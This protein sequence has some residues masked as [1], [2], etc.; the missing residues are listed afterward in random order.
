MWINVDQS[1][2]AR[3]EPGIKLFSL[4]R[5]ID[6][7]FTTGP[8]LSKISIFF[9]VPVF[10]QFLFSCCHVCCFLPSLFSGVPFVL[11]HLEFWNVCYFTMEIGVLFFLD[12]VACG[13]LHVCF[14]EEIMLLLSHPPH[15]Q[16]VGLCS[17]NLFSAGIRICIFWFSQCNRT[18]NFP[19]A[20]DIGSYLSL[21]A[22]ISFV[23]ICS[24]FFQFAWIRSYVLSI[25]LF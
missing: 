17:F 20:R 15:W 2:S 1:V 22:L 12:I 18:I 19:F 8:R 13:G 16:L 25:V 4:I 5:W 6:P 10:L 11:L 14:W 24:H 23:H 3:H 9:F 7:Q 21:I